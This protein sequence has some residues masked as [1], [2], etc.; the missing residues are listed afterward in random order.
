VTGGYFGIVGV[1]A[2]MLEPV[3]SRRRGPW[4]F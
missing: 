2:R 4:L 1:V 3:P